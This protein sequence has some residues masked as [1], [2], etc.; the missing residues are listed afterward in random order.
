MT[1][2]TGEVPIK[3]NPASIRTP[4]PLISLNATKL[5]AKPSDIVKC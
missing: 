3:D 5:G 2:A 1:N 4:I